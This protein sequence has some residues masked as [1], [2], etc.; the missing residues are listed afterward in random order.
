MTD[1]KCHVI[2]LKRILLTRPKT[3]LKS[4]RLFFQLRRPGWGWGGGGGG[5]GGERAMG[6]WDFFLLCPTI[7]CACNIIWG[8]PFVASVAFALIFKYAALLSGGRV[9]RAPRAI[10]WRRPWFVWSKW[11]NL[12]QKN[13][14]INM[15]IK[16]VLYTVQI[17]WR[18]L[19]G[20]KVAK[21]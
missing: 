6:K 7:T 13:Y 19:V 16:G 14:T 3:M 5:G 4:T 8:V 11:A 10:T 9:G 15:I 17:N 21:K 2:H 20:K 12:K 1:Q 18:Q